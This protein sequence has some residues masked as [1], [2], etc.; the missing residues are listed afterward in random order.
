MDNTSNGLTYN[1]LKAIIY[2]MLAMDENGNSLVKNDYLL[3]YNI[4][5]LLLGFLTEMDDLPSMLY[6]Y[7]IGYKFV[8]YLWSEIMAA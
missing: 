7:S 4:K 2:E 8:D 5:Y 3:H 6:R 1:N